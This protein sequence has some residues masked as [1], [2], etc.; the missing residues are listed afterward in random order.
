M[1]SSD[2]QTFLVDMDF[3]VYYKS[4]VKFNF[5]FLKH[6]RG[7]MTWTFNNSLL[8][9]EDDIVFVKCINDIIRQY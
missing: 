4:P 5:K 8:Q 7:R 3:D 9:D 6:K 1:V 2:L